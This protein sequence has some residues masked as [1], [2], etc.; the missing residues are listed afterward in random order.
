[1]NTTEDFLCIL[2]A[3][4]LS[5]RRRDLPSQTKISANSQSITFLSLPPSPE[6]YTL[7]SDD[8][9]EYDE[10]DDNDYDDYDYDDDDCYHDNRNKNNKAKY[11]NFLCY[12]FLPLLRRDVQKLWGILHIQFAPPTKHTWSRLMRERVHFLS[13]KSG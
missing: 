6:A 7:I 3:E 8:H 1:M 11:F 2:E 5:R 12:S 4:I 13:Q 9:D 10:D